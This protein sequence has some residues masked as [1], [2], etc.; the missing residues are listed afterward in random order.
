VATEYDFPATPPRAYAA[1]FVPL[2]AGE[3]L[4]DVFEKAWAEADPLPH[5]DGFTWSA[6]TYLIDYVA[7][8]LGTTP[9]AA[10]AATD[11]GED[12]PK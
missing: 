10:S 9:Q 3:E 8:L 11:D 2:G 5:P 1:P 4:H 7:A 12:T 6:E